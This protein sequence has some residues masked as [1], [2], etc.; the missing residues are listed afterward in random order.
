MV[1]VLYRAFR[2]KRQGADESSDSESM[3]ELECIEGYKK[4]RKSKG[5]VPGSNPGDDISQRNS[6][7]S[8]GEGT[9]PRR[10]P[11]SR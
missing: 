1:E 4:S 10:T 2:D 8:S 5:E 9:V 11:G 6:S 7:M 3:Y